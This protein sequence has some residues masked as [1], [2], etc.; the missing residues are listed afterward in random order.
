MGVRWAG[1]ESQAHTQ[2]YDGDSR[3]GRGVAVA[4]CWGVWDELV[5][6]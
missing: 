1:Q 2:R 4:G 6:R 5:S 3:W